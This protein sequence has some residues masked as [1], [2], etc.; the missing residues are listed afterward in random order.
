M[1]AVLVAAAA[2]SAGPF[3]PKLVGANAKWVAHVDVQ[4]IL[5]SGLGKLAMEKL[6]DEA[7]REKMAEVQELFGLDLE[8]DLSGV[9]LWGPAYGPT[10]G[11]AMFQGRFDQEKILAV[12]QQ[13]PGYQATA[14]GE[15]TILRWTD[16]EAAKRNKNDDG[17]RFGVFYCEDV[18]AV[19][20]SRDVLT[21]ALDQLARQ[22]GTLAAGQGDL[23]L[24]AVEARPLVFAAGL[25][26]RE[27]AKDD[28]DA[29]WLQ[30]VT[31][32]CLQVSQTDETVSMNVR[33]GARDAQTGQK[34]RKV[35]SGL[36]ALAELHVDQATQA[37][38]PAP[39]WAPL[40]EAAE[41]SGEGT[42]VE[43]DVSLAQETLIEVG[44]AAREAK[45]KAQA[46]RSAGNGRDA[47]IAGQTE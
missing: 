34:L 27:A 2:G 10:A 24:P 43:L 22:D 23:P 15:H 19:A 45:E 21:A 42:A 35:L 31:A 25:N 14:H 16:E 6:R 33:L 8:K 36:L 26:P 32:G 47:V 38:R 29:A 28:P 46:A 37:E 9:T 17:T 1:A 11:V 30:L 12:L 3:E 39:F 40:V 4:G 7:M 44:R 5:N 18:A 20:R 41:V 13:A